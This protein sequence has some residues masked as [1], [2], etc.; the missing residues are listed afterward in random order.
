MKVLL[1]AGT[2]E[3]RVLARLMGRAGVPAVASLAGATDAPE[4]LDLPTRVGGFGGA[5]EFA[6]YLRREDVTAVIDATHP[7]ARRITDRTAAI[8]AARGM[9]YLQLLRPGWVAETGDDWH[10]I[11]SAKDAAALIPAGATVFLATGRKT[12]GDFAGLEGRRVLARVIDP[13]RAPFPFEGGEFIIA[14][15][16]YRFDAE[17]ALFAELGV[18]WLVTKDA[19]GVAGRAK[20]DAAFALGIPVAILRRPPM[21]VAE[22]VETPEKAMDWVRALRWR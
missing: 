11:D 5:E 17:K 7:F 19:G 1:L 16:P 3:A 22:R 18:T 4:K 20:L 8:C 12:L 6:D 10:W 2:T 15:P 14:R 13:P 21:P 9:P